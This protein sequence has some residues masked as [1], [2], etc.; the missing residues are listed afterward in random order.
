MADQ[1]GY[2]KPTNP[3]PASG[4]GRLSKRTD[5]GPGQKLMVPSGL[6]YGDR[7][8]L[9]DQERTAAMYQVDPVQTPDVPAPR[10]NPPAGQSP[11]N[12]PPFG[13]PTQRPDEPITHGVDIGA[14]GG[15]EVLPGPAQP[16][17]ANSPGPMT[18]LLGSLPLSGE[19]ASLY[20]AASSLGV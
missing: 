2:R 15:S 14:G 18:T 9:Q 20:S 1:G 4:P 7:Q 16:P 17:S 12:G 19:L 6:P 13:A 11:Y 5:G 8:G 10:P 3:A